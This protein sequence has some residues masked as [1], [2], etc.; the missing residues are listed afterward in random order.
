MN[1]VDNERRIRLQT[2]QG[3]IEGNLRL[4][5]QVRTLD[6]L[7]IGGKPF[8]ILNDPEFTGSIGSFQKSPVSINKRSILFVQELSAPPQKVA[9]QVTHGQFARASLQL[10]VSEYK[11]EGFLH[12]APGGSPMLRL[13]QVTHDFIS[14]TSVSVL[15]PDAHFAAPFMAI[16]RHHIMAAQ[17]LGF[18]E[19]VE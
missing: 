14:L 6:D 18:A 16:Q 17:E 1:T 5:A 13:N 15:G 19:P 11:I 3:I 2:V 10:Q 8:I 7:N 9:T 4:A 12:V